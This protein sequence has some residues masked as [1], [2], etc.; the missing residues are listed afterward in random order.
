M[1]K[2]DEIDKKIIMSLQADAA[3]SVAAIGE[4]VG[5][6]QNACWRRIRRLEDE[7]YLKARI[8]IFDNEKLGHPVTVFAI[9][10]VREHDKESFEAFARKITAMPE[11]LEFY[12]MSGEI[13]YMAKILA[14]DVKHYDDIYKRIIATKCIL[15]VSSSFAMEE[16]KFTT[17]IPVS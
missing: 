10:K 13:D 6:S 12:R 8:A 16:I 5:L 4:R 17:A 9:L 14:R 7:K 11:V 3:Q 1:G 2:L 15:S